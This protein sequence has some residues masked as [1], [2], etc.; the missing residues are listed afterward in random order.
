[1][2]QAVTYIELQSPDL[3]ASV[4]FFTE[5]FGWDPQPFATPDYLVSPAGSTHGIDAGLLESRDGAPRT[6][7]VINVA[8]LDETLK[9]VAVRGG[10]LVV[11]P[12][13]ISGV[14]RGC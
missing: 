12:F 2:T 13:A 5:V 7:S 10:R 6:V 4:Q 3:K 8:S 9:Q 1:M 14:G 11:E